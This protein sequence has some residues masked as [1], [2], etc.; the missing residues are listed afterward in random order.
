MSQTFLKPGVIPGESICLK[1]TSHS[2]IFDIPMRPV[3]EDQ[4]RM[5]T[6]YTLKKARNSRDG[7]YSFEFCPLHAAHAKKSLSEK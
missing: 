7:N 1:A 6:F 4:R 5:K 3:R 2:T